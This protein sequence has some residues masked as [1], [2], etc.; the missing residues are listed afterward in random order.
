[1]LPGEVRS[2]V[3]VNLVFTLAS[4][5]EACRSVAKLQKSLA[6]CGGTL[7]E[8]LLRAVPS[9]KPQAAARRCGGLSISVFQRRANTTFARTGEGIS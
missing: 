5:G 2:L 4:R 9:A 8:A 3:G 7:G 1:M 6:L